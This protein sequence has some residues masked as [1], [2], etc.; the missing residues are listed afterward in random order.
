[1]QGRKIQ[2]NI[3][4]SATKPPERTMTTHSSDCE[5]Y[6]L[7]AHALNGDEQAFD[8]LITKHQQRLHA[9]ACPV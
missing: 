7:L 4:T 3:F 9:I 2:P 5:D 8:K 6:V 1:M